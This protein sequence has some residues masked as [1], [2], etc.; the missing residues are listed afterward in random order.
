M[1]GR[2]IWPQTQHQRRRRGEALLDFLLRPN[3]CA[4][5]IVSGGHVRRSAV[6]HA[7]KI[8]DTERKTLEKE[9][10]KLPSC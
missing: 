6:C 7:W 5:D 10:E 9:M 2:T 1:F 3:D 4:D 8:S